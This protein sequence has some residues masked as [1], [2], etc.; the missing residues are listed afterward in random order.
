MTKEALLAEIENMKGQQQRYLELHHQATGAIAS[1][2]WVLKNTP[3]S[4]I[5]QAV[6]E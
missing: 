6:I 4:E 5:E 2:E 1:L 3:E